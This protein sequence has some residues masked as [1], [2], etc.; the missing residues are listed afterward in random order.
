MGLRLE[1]QSSPLGGVAY[2]ALPPLAWPL[3]ADCFSSSSAACS[4]LLHPQLL[5]NIEIKVFRLR[6]EAL[7]F[8]WMLTED[9]GIWLPL[10][11]GVWH[12]VWLRHLLKPVVGMP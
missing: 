4:G 9:A 12:E 10:L 1:F 3:C 7:D 8:R 6:Q 11:L 5:R 2:P